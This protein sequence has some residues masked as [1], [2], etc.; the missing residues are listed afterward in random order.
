MFG[1]LCLVTSLLAVIMFFRMEDQTFRVFSSVIAVWH[2]A[3]GLGISLRTSW[4]F[5]LLKIN[6]YILMLGVPLGT[7]LARYL[8]RYIRENQIREFF[9]NRSLII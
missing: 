2:L 7:M 3:T 9:G 4:G 8:L 1:S 6:L 5:H